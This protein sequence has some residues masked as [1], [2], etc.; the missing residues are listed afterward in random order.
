LVINVYRCEIGAAAGTDTRTNL[1]FDRR[2][3][4]RRNGGLNRDNSVAALGDAP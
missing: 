1:N 3:N 4:Q 2:L